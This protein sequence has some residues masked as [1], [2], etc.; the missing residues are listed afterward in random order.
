MKDRTF[1]SQT[2]FEEGIFMRLLKEEGRKRKERE[3]GEGQIIFYHPQMY[4]VDSV[5]I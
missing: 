5:Y 2:I 4:Y 1:F 3:K